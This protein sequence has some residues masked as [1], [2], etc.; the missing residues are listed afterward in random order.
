[1]TS[2]W[3]MYCQWRTF[4][5]AVEVVETGTAGDVAQLA[6]EAELVSADAL[7]VHDVTVLRALRVTASSRPAWSE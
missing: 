3:Y 7:A 1:M 4:A 5:T 6:L 2:K